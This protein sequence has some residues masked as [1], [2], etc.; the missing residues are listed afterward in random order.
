MACDSVCRAIARESIYERACGKKV[1]VCC[2]TVKSDSAFVRT[3][4]GKLIMLAQ[5]VKVGGVLV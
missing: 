3:S 1:E 4:R 2:M 5:N